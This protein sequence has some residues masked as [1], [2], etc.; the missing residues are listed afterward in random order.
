MMMNIIKNNE[1][2]VCFCVVHKF[3][4]V[5]IFHQFFHQQREIGLLPTTTF[6]CVKKIFGHFAQMM[7]EVLENLLNI[8]SGIFII[9]FCVI[10]PVKLS[11]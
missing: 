10:F 7:L 9:F 1:L 11:L 5:S 6:L 3:Y 2:I 8:L 4:G